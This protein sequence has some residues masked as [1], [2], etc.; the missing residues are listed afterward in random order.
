MAKNTVEP[1]II[2]PSRIMWPRTVVYAYLSRTIENTANQKA[3][4]P[5]YIRRYSTD[6]SHD[7]VRQFAVFSLVWDKIVIQ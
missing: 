5:L 2:G 4:K 1:Y 3:G 6:P 7:T